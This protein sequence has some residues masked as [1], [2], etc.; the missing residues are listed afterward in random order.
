MI[1]EKGL[2]TLKI[3]PVYKDL[4]H[5]L[6]KYEYEQLVENICRDGCTVPIVTWRG[7]I[8]DGHNRYEI[9]HK[10]RIPFS[11]EERDFYS[12]DEVISWICANQLGRRNI[13]EETRKYL[14]GKRYDAEKIIN[15]RK[16]ALGRN[17]FLDE[18]PDEKDARHK[19]HR[20]ANILGEEYHLSHGTVQKYAIYSRAM[21]SIGKKDHKLAAKILAGNYKVSHENVVELSKLPLEEVKKVSRGIGARS[22]RLVSFRNTRQEIQENAE[23]RKQQEQIVGPSVK[24]MPEFDPDAEVSS[25]SLTVPSWIGS[26]QRTRSNSDFANVSETAKTSL[27]KVLFQLQECIADM[28]KDVRGY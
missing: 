2:H 6:S 20:T 16:N 27:E 19:E 14:I 18:T 13:S 12:R 25:L 28:L 22:S 1:S 10:Y 24:D 21:D 3:D 23:R 17:K 9:C 4:I 15:S 7:T 8:I 5:P 26:I 11:Y